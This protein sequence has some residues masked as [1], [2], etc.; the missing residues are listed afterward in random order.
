MM[1]VITVFVKLQVLK[2]Q[3]K[4]RDEQVPAGKLNKGKAAVTS[5]LKR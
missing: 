2:T 3:W 4:H 5:A 1:L